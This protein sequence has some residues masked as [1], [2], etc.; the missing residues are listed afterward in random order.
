MALFSGGLVIVSMA[1]NAQLANRIGIFK[2]TLVNY[3]VGLISTLALLGILNIPVKPY[4]KLLGSVPIWAFLGGCLGVAVVATSNIVIPKVPTIY[5]TLLSFAGQLLA[6]ILI[7]ILINGSVS[8]GKA[9]GAVLIFA[10]VLLN[11]YIDRTGS[12]SNCET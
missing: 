7:D 6:G 11:S 2:G 1:L 12:S 5:V 10:G 8:Y 3:T 9:I 4:L